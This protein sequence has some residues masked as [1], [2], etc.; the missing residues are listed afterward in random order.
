MEN[1]LR[2]SLA[3]Q[4]TMKADNVLAFNNDE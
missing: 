1:H 4:K 2:Q 3:E